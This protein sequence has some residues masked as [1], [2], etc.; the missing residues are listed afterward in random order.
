VIIDLA[1]GDSWLC[2]QVFQQMAV[3]WYQFD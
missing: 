1:D 2:Q 3:V